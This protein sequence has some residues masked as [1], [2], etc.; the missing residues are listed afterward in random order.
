[1]KI[2]LSKKY[3]FGGKE[4]E[5]FELNLEALTGKDIMDCEREFKVRNKGTVAT[6]ETEDSWALIIAAK[7][8]DVKYG[9]LLTLNATDY[10]KT[11]NKIKLFLAQGWEEEKKEKKQNVD[12]VDTPEII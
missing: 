12:I 9:D 1:M 8:L 11:I 3:N 6:K 10:L 5:E 4:F 2:E 7:V